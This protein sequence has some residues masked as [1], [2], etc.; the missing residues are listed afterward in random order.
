MS[1][2]FSSYATTNTGAQL[3]DIIDQP[4]YLFEFR[5]LSEDGK[6]AVQA[7]ARDVAPIINA[8]PSK[9]ERDAASQFVGW[10]VGQVMRDT[11]YEVAKERGR[12]TDA[13][14]KTGAVWRQIASEP[15]LVTEAPSVSGPGRLEL[16]VV[17]DNGELVADWEVT[18][19]ATSRITGH[20][21]RVHTIK[22]NRRPIKQAV[23]E[24][25]AYAKRFGFPAVWVN[26]PGRC[27]P[28]RDWP[29]R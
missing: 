5:R 12:V 18:T 7:V 15:I 24:A 22:S 10:Y 2:W 13:P 4:E 17:S 21:R 9:R 3:A 20:P 16:R 1:N 8:L 26:D 23:E 28:K 11:G 6:P 29:V 19:T 27:F 25:L 14:Y